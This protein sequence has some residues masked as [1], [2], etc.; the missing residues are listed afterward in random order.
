MTSYKTADE[1]SAIRATPCPKFNCWEGLWDPADS[2]DKQPGTHSIHV[3]VWINV[4]PMASL[5]ANEK[6]LEE[7]SLLFFLTM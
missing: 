5:K 7:E 4:K 1:S 2:C 3:K 6:K